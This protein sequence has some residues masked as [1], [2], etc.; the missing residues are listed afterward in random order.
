MSKRSRKLFSSGRR[1]F[2]K[3][4]ATIGV[5][6]EALRHMS[7]ESLAKVTSDPTKEVPRLR[8]LQHTNHEEVMNEN[9]P[10]ERKPV[11]YT[12]PRDEWAYNEGIQ[13][14]TMRVK[15]QL[16][17]RLD[18]CGSSSGA[19]HIT[20]AFR[21][22]TSGHHK[23]REVVVQH[24]TLDGD[25]PDVSLEEVRE[26][27][28]SKIDGHARGA[29]DSE[30][31]EDVPVVVEKEDFQYLSGGN[32]GEYDYNYESDTPAGAELEAY[33]R[34]TAGTPA[35]HSG[36]DEFVMLTVNH[37][38]DDGNDE[39]NRYTAYQPDHFADD[40][41]NVIRGKTE[42]DGATNLTCDEVTMDAASLSFNEGLTYKLAGS[43]GGYQNAEIY[44]VLG[45]D[46]IVDNQ[47][48][49]QRKQ[50]TTTGVT[51]GSVDCTNPNTKFYMINAESDD[52]DSGGPLNR[53]TWYE[54]PTSFRSVGAMLA[55]GDSSK[56]GGI[57]L[58]EVESY[59]NVSI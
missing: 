41:G 11:Y 31:V 19:G 45:W 21:E 35:Y 5:S 47:G 22:T 6:G 54:H 1:Q 26:K 30:I 53:E 8:G 24:V 2:L 49:S 23:R 42:P 28:P 58:S 4:L 29:K 34:G 57:H 14:A 20:T 7:Q 46:W 38:L 10:P 18:T 15:Q 55:I 50:G 40:Y 52:G 48:K 43:N 9:V 25:N 13:N 32:D 44:E 39:S 59:L 16:D 17:S 33:T 51:S 3:S 37:I 12:I 36:R 56:C 27:T